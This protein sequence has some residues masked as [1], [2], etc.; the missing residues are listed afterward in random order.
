MNIQRESSFADQML[1]IINLNRI[2]I[3]LETETLK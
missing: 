1:Y 2:I 3:K